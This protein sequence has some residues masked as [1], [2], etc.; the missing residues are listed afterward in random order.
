MFGSEDVPVSLIGVL[1]NEMVERVETEFA[2]VSGL[3]CG[4]AVSVIESNESD[5]LT[6]FFPKDGSERLAEIEELFVFFCFMSNSSVVM[7]GSEVSDG[8]LEAAGG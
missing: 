4:R 2:F 7:A 1:L 5:V 8:V 6:F 3:D